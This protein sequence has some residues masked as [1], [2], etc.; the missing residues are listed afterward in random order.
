MDDGRF[1]DRVVAA[2]GSARER[3]LEDRAESR[4]GE[5]MGPSLWDARRGIAYRAHNEPG[6][7][8]NM[9]THIC[10]RFLE[11]CYIW[12]NMAVGRVSYKT[13]LGSCT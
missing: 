1:S 12:S 8:R 7:P 9:G 2:G 3:R 13:P 10:I 4:L 6:M 11:R 5:G